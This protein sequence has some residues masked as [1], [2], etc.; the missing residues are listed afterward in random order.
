MGVEIERKYL[1][2]PTIWKQTAKLDGLKCVQTY[3]ST[4][5]NKTIRVRVMG[6][7]AYITIKGKTNHLSRTEFEYEI[8]LNEGEELIQLFGDKVLEKTRYIIPLGHHNWEVDV[9]EGNNKG[10]IVAEIEL[11]SEDEKFEKPNWL[12]EEVSHDPR[13]YNACLQQT[14]F[15]DW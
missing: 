3:L 12:G 10:L 8:P 9:F 7:K 6:D 13:Y 11:E 2:N 15:C 5:P 4:D 1:V 14:P